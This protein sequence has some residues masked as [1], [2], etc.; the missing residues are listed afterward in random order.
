[1]V[2]DSDSRPTHAR[3]GAPA[4]LNAGGGGA[5]SL[6]VNHCPPGWTSGQAEFLTSLFTALTSTKIVP[7]F[8]PIARYRSEQDD[9]D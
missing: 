3:D 8:C 4:R 9:T 7:N 2:Q 1:V 5:A 6:N